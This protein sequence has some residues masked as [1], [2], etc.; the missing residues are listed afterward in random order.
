V[1]TDKINRLSNTQLLEL[2]HHVLTAI[3][4]EMPTANF[5]TF[6]AFDAVLRHYGQLGLDVYIDRYSEPFTRYRSYINSVFLHTEDGRQAFMVPRFTS[7]D[8]GESALLKKWEAEVYKAYRTA[9]PQARVHWINCDS[10]VSS[11]GFL[12]CISVTVPLL[13]RN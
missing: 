1:R 3:K 10:M 11:L 13:E 8:P 9:W 4:K 12:H 2:E 5:S 7:S 6:K